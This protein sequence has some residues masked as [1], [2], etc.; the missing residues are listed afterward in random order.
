VPGDELHRA[1]A[2]S[3]GWLPLLIDFL[4]FLKTLGNY[5][6]FPEFL[7][8]WLVRPIF[9]FQVSNFVKVRQILSEEG[10]I[11]GE[12]DRGNFQIH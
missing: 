12:G 9:K 3:I 10:R 2:R 4:R 11:L 7:Y 5:L 8:L 6:I 1:Q